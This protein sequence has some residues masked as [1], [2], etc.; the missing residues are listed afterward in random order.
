VRSRGVA[1]ASLNAQRFDMATQTATFS[2]RSAP[3]AAAKN[4]GDEITLC[5]FTAAHAQIKSRTLHRI[6]LPLA[7]AGVQIQYV[8]PARET[9]THEGVEFVRIPTARSRVGRVVRSV[10][11]LRELARLGAT[12]YHFQDPELLP[13]GFALKALFR[14]RVI[15]DAYED[16]PSMAE[17]SSSLPRWTR[18]P[19]ARVVRMAEH[20]AAC[21]FDAITTADPF[22]LKRLARAGQ[23]KKRVF[24]NFPNLDFFPDVAATPK[25]F[26]IVYRGGLSDR[27]G[28]YTLLDAL[29]LLKSRAEKPRLLLIGYFD[30]SGA[31]RALEERIRALALQEQV[32]IVGRVEH[33]AMAE[34]LSRARIGVC[35][36]EDLPKFRLNIPVKVFEYLACGLPVVSTDLP[37]IRPFL[38]NSQ[39]GLLCTPG[40]AADMA[41]AIGW[42]LDHPE[43]ARRMGEQGHR[44]IEARFNNEGEAHKLLMLC[45]QIAMPERVRVKQEARATNA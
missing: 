2:S 4:G 13:V 21:S 45:R 40:D 30:N 7:A 42:L 23:S 27:A 20:L 31:Q 14:K 24:Y 36:L 34:A 12:I 43:D 9:P 8:S 1:D 41:R 15:Y 5:H 32:E 44:L 18:G 3:L 6:C 38:R 35:P 39:A 25:P 19:A 26:D 22:T 33:E 16:F 11:L 10:K 37:P 17:A 29:D 28:T